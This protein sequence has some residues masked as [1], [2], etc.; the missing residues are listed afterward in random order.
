MGPSG[1][2]E[3]RNN[4]ASAANDGFRWQF[5]IQNDV[6]IEVKIVCLR[7]SETE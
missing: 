5:G 2:P 3:W 1:H 6:R 7:V 4:K